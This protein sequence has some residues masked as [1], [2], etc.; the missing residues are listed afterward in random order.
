MLI[1]TLGLSSLTSQDLLLEEVSP[2][3]EVRLSENTISICN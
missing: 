3:S 2:N 1:A